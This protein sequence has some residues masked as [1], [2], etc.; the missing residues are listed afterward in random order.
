[1]RLLI[2]FDLHDTLVNST[3]AWLKAYKRM[4]SN[5][6]K[7]I[8]K[9]YKNGMF[10]KD[11]CKKYDIEYEHL[12]EIYREYLHENKLVLKY[13]DLIRNNY[14][15]CIITNASSIRARK[16]L[17]HCNIKYDKLYTSED[18]LKPDKKYIYKIMKENKCDFL[19]LIGNQDEDILTLTNTTSY[20]IKNNLQIIN[21]YIKIK[22][23]YGRV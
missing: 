3:K 18:G 8:K 4:N 12:K 1:M 9:D 11:I 13:Y 6:Y 19:I 16:D 10:R 5:E 21:I 15:T 14:D 23:K 20:L 2:A 22:R 17:E 7:K